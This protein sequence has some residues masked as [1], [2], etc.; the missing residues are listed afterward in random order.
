MPSW[1]VLAEEGR[2]ALEI[3]PHLI[4]FPGLLIFLTMLSFNIIGDALRD[5]LDPFLR[6]R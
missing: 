3:Y 2:Q 4:I 5:R 1:G 6:E